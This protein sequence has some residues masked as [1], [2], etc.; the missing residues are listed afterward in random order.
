MKTTTDAVASRVK[1]LRIYIKGRQRH[2]FFHSQFHGPFCITRS[3]LSCIMPSLRRIV[4]A[5][6]LMR[7]GVSDNEMWTILEV[8]IYI[9]CE[10][11]QKF[12]ENKRK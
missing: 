12:E 3:A 1:A 2:E 9:H 7:W 4:V 8:I 5:G 11:D 6:V 10:L